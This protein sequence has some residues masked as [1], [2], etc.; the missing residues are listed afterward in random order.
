LLRKL[1]RGR[2]DLDPWELELA[3]HARIELEAE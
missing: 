1:E 3:R 2:R